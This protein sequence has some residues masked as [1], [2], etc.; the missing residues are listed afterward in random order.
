MTFL[1]VREQS[2]LA[3]NTGLY[4]SGFVSPNSPVDYTICG[5]MQERVY[6]VPNTAIPAAVTSHLKQRLINTW[7]SIS[8]NVINEAVSQWRKR[9]R[10]RQ[11]DITLNIC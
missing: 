4:L 7:A 10:L 3:G 8:Q 5:L 6:I 9:L 2:P 11:K 1:Y